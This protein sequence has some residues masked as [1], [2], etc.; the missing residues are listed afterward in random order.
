MFLKNWAR[1]T[2]WLISVPANNEED[3]RRAKL[4]ANTLVAIFITSAIAC[5]G[6]LIEPKN[7]V[8]TTIIFYGVT[9]SL[10]CGIVILFRKGKIIV[11]GWV[12]VIFLWLTV[13]FATLFFGGLREHSVVFVVVIMFMGSFLGGRAAIILS[14]VTICF[15][16]LV[17]YL[18]I[19]G[20]M[21]FQLGPAY[22]PLNA[23]SSL[24]I[25]IMLMSVLL[26]NSLKSLK[27]SE[28]R[29]HLAVRGS[30]AGLWDWNI[31]TNDVY[32][33]A[34]F[35][36]ML[37][38]SPTEPLRSFSSFIELIH[39]DDFENMKTSI[40]NHLGSL[41]S[42][43]NVEFRI[44]MKN[45]SYRWFETR[46]EAVFNTE[47]KPYRMV[48]SMVDITMRK[49][50]EASIAQK[51][52]ELIKINTELDR[53]VYSAS[54]D[55]RA[56]IS[57]LLG[58]IEVARLENDPSTLR[59]L[60]DMQ[61][62]SLHKLDKFIFD[63]VNYSRNNRVEIEV[64]KIDFNVLLDEAFELLSY[65][66]D[67]KNIKVIKEIDSSLFFYS[68]KKRLSVIL[69]NLISNTF[70]YCDMSK[71]N[72]FIKIVVEKSDQGACIR[73]IDNG[74]GINDEHINKIFDM[75]YRATE[76]STGSGIGLYIVKE[77]VEKL[78]GRIE[79]QSQ[80]NIGSEFIIRLPSLSN[81]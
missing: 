37:G 67:V 32:Y 36:E 15:L 17:A 8:G 76:R 10:L 81:K 66:D 45:G 35:K 12:L 7:N 79:V 43:Y 16:G 77:V 24:C 34:T 19:N 41:R 29:F 55:L 4:L 61:E 1:L 42:K 33:S 47:D 49:L 64:E 80:R 56:P 65:I 31:L 40:D 22:T 21:P 27:E 39:P 70:K 23:L 74:E 58:L 28:E 50:A 68:D 72:S 11:T 2:N 73:I 69:N 5:V 9:S 14:F 6:G 44:Q 60:L 46:G 38:Y 59:R 48:G 18:E 78:H 3:S 25:A 62:R 30:A 20:L 13:A 51:N 26:H 71:S 52:E 54:H 75:F 57:S 63:I 53:F